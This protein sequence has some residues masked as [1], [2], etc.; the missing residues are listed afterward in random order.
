MC[1]ILKS[2][3]LETLRNPYHTANGPSETASTRSTE[4]SL[5]LQKPAAALHLGIDLKKKWNATEKKKR[6]GSQIGR[7]P[8]YPP[9]GIKHPLLHPRIKKL[10]AGKE[11]YLNFEG[12]E[13]AKQK[14]EN[15]RRRYNIKLSGHGRRLFTP[16]F[17]LCKVRLLRSKEFDNLHP[18]PIMRH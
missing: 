11:I 1:N 4:T 8:R 10:E 3:A 15:S 7:C 18:P 13:V 17:F 14:L 2:C 16:L 6:E 12:I 5:R 9:C